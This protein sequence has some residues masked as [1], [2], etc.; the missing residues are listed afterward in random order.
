[1]YSPGLIRA[2]N[3]LQK[4]WQRRWREA[5]G[6]PTDN[7]PDDVACDMEIQFDIWKLDKDKLNWCFEVFPNG[8]KVL[9]RAVDIRSIKV[10]KGLFEDVDLLATLESMIDNAETVIKQTSNE[11]ATKEI[12]EIKNCKNRKVISGDKEL[13][14]D[15]RKNSYHVTYPLTE[16]LEDLFIEL[17][18]ERGLATYSFLGEPL[19]RID[20][21]FVVRDAILWSAI[22]EH[23]SVNPFDPAIKLYSLGAY[24]GWDRK[25][26]EVFVFVER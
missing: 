16:I 14:F 7:M 15:K 6:V 21:D 19:Y 26:D 24:A 18:A 1:M 11:S 5:L 12:N 17:Y 2:S 20:H 10:E 4:E 9:E 8:Q 3:E 25:N 23:Y 22:E 13:L